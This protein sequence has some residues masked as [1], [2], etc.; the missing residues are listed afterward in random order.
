M[1]VT[2]TAAGGARRFL[3]DVRNPLLSECPGGS[4]IRPT[5][6]IDRLLRLGA[7]AEELRAKRD[8]QGRF[9]RDAGSLTEWLVRG[10]TPQKGR[11]CEQQPS[12]SSKFI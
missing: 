5:V 2:G 6:V 10:R 8:V 11:R 4:V 7:L 12:S 9:K 1:R 3:R